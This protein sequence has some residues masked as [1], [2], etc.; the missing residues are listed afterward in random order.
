MKCFTIRSESSKGTS[1]A[2]CRFIRLSFLAENFVIF[3]SLL[4]LSLP[5]G[6]TGI[7]FKKSSVGRFNCSDSLPSLGGILAVISGGGL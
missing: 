1:Q 4:S 5:F 3:S 2:L 6:I 7:A